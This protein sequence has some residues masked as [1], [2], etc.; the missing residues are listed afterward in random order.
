VLI[1]PLAADLKF[2]ATVDSNRIVV[3]PP[4]DISL[5]DEPFVNYLIE[6]RIQPAVMDLFLVVR[7]WVEDC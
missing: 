6:I 7:S 4:V 2:A 5:P 1:F 3:H